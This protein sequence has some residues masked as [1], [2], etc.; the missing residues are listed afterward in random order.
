VTA[1]L[2]RP[3]AL[4]ADRRRAFLEAFAKVVA[5]RVLA[6]LDAMNAKRP[7]PGLD[8]ASR[9]EQENRRGRHRRA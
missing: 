9:E 2:E 1:P 5:R 4:P 6:E 3:K 7:G 8:G